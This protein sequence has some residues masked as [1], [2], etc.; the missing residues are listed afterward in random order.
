MRGIALGLVFLFFLQCG[1]LEK[2][3]IFNEL[4]QM[5]YSR[6]LDEEKLTAWLNHIDPEI[7]QRAVDVIGRVQDASFIVPLSNQL[8]EDDVPAIRVSAA[9]ALG[10]MFSPR[11]EPYLIESIKTERYPQ[12][13]LAA[14]DALGK[15]GTRKS[16]PVLRRYLFRSAPSVF[17]FRANIATGVLAYRGYP[18]YENTD[19]IEILLQ[20]DPSDSVRWSAAY[21]LYRIADPTT[22][23]HLTRALSDTS[24]FTRFFAL[25]GIRS[26]L[27]MMQHPDFRKLPANEKVTENVRFSR[28]REFREALRKAAEDTVWFNRIAFLECV[29]V[30]Q[31]QRQLYRDVVQLLGDSNPNVQLEAIHT[32][33]QFKTGNTIT[34]LRRILQT[35]TLD[36]RIRGQA[37]IALAQ[38]STGRALRWIQQNLNQTRWPELY[39]SI[40]ALQQI[41]SPAATQL[42][43]ELVNASEIPV[44]SLALEALGGRPEVPT[45]LLIE[46]LRMVDPAISAIAAAQIAARRDTLAVTPLMEVYEQ[47]KA[48]RDIEPMQAILAA[49]DSLASPQALPLLEKEL[50]NPFPPIREYARRALVHI[51]RDST[52]TIPEVPSKSLT[53]WDF[54]LPDTTRTWLAHIHTPRGKIT[55]RLLPE[56]APVTVANFIELARAGFYNGLI[57]HRVVPGFVIQGGDPRGDGWGGPGYTIPCEYSATLY[58]RG[59]VGIAHA[60]KDTGGSQF[61]ITHTPQ[62]HLNGRY[63]VFARVTEG[64]DVVDAIT[65]FDKI[66]RIEIESSNNP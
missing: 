42:L 66:E 61:F 26:I 6:Q 37:L 50:E 16:H 4:H 55:L 58:D 57:F 14:I 30:F 23:T 28:S 36:F 62:P 46:K 53:R 9:V 65:I 20:Y 18:A 60:G 25:K 38:V 10:Q 1:K 22:L 31:P 33:A 59:V 41:D 51:L 21:A 8:L 45:S 29:D 34:L 2:E 3:V 24:A 39:F 15:S 32:L 13:V 19:V 47:F 63:T 64:M 43:M 48:P 56:L 7:R 17:K 11:A 44:V 12:V 40:K 52:I 49:L 54:P 27:E 5:E 35:D